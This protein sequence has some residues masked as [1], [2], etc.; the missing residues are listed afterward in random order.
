[1][2]RFIEN[3]P[4]VFSLAPPASAVCFFREGRYGALSRRARDDVRHF[5]TVSKRRTVNASLRSSKV[6]WVAKRKI[7]FFF[8]GIVIG[9]RGPVAPFATVYE[10]RL[11][12]LASYKA[13]SAARKRSPAL[14]ACTGYKA[15]PP[16]IPNLALLFP[17]TGGA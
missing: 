5:D 13:A 12:F 15:I 10:P 1:M 3:F 4:K 2:R 17:G 9:C 16:V 7:Q 11:C 8:R 6:R 14:R